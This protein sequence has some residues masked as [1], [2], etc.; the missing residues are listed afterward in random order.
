MKYILLALV[1]CLLIIAN[2][3]ERCSAADTIGIESKRSFLTADSSKKRIAIVGED[4]ELEWEQK[5][6]PLHD[7]HVLASGNVLFQRNWTHVVEVDP[8]SGVVV[9]Q[10]NCADD[11]DNKGRKIEVHAFQRLANGHTMLVESGSTRILEVDQQGK[12]VF[13]MPMRV[14]QSHPHR[15]TRLVRKLSGGNYLVCHEGDGRVREYRAIVAKG[16]ITAKPE[17]VWDYEV[18]MFGREASNGHG[19]EA[20]GNQCFC[21][22]R[23]ENGNT[24]IS[25]GNGHSIIEV[26]PEKEIVWKLTQDELPGIQLAWVTTLQRLP[27][28][29]I[30][31]GNCH[32]GD[33]N[34]QI[35]EIN[36]KKEVVWEFHDLRRFG[37]ATTNTQILTVDGEKIAAKPGR[38]R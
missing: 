35:V 33:S 7:L 11:P 22:L 14:S 4:G 9:W 17:I 31:I 1:V 19:I 15:D 23:L 20:F 32:A 21:A 13:E 2:P 27:S 34:P 16:A 30:V 10:Y 26:T 18:P 6:G 5:I 37:N 36:R 38:D 24:L 12:I 28:G 8:K 29:N 25:T 3:A